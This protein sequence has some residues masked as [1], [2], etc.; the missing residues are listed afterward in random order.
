MGSSSIPNYPHRVSGPLFHLTRH[1]YSKACL[2]VLTLCLTR[3]S[4]VRLS[5]GTFHGFP[6]TEIPSKQWEGKK[7]NKTKYKQKPLSLVVLNPTAFLHSSLF[8][9]QITKF[10]THRCSLFK[11]LVY[12]SAG[13]LPK[14]FYFQSK[15]FKIMS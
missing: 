7:N 10:E 14:C 15:G 1:C 2:S 8:S 13:H 5:L 6:S 12:V 3:C 4:H 11:Y 9:H